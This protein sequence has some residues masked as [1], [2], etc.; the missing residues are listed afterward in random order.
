M[1]LIFFKTLADASRLRLLGVLATGERSVDE[2]AALLEL[3]APTVSHHLARLRSLGLVTLRVDGNVHW[4]R[5]DQDALRSLSRDVLS[6]ER[7]AS[8]ADDIEAEGWE[9]KILRDFFDGERLK[10]I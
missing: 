4:Y 8:F 6:L 9:K 3:R 5:L 7:V 2:L 10:E 1:P